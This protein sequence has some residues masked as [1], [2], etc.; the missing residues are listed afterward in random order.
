M[1]TTSIGFLDRLKGDAAD[2]DWRRF[3][4][5]YEPLFR[6]WLARFGV[7]GADLDE[8]LSDLITSVVRGLP[9]FAHPGTPGAFRGWLYTVLTNAVRVHRR[10]RAA[11]PGDVGAGGDARR[12][13]DL[14]ADDDLAR[15][16][17]EE[18][19]RYVVER[20]LDWLRPE[21]DP[22]VWAAF[23]Q[24]AVCGRTAAAVAAELGVTTN[25]V[26]ISRSRVLR[27]LRDVAAGWV[28]ATES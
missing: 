22:Q 20:L 2:D 18:H 27:R 9:R 26:Y 16:W 19:D 3:V 21:F 1:P 11:R 25:A 24:T 5:V 7:K 15:R 13:D 12:L 6:I 10:K 23:E 4:R 8:V 17:D 14:P 28:N